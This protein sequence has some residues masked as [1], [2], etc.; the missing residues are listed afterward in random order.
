MNTVRS[1]K[2]CMGEFHTGNFSVPQSFSSSFGSCTENQDSS[3]VRIFQFLIANK[4][5]SRFCAPLLL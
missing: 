1:F 4:D 3:K 2:S 5:R